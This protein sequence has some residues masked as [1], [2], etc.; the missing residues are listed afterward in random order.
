MPATATAA[1]ASP[2]HATSHDSTVASDPDVT[3]LDR[4]LAD[5]QS[6]TAV[7]RFSH[8][9][10]DVRNH[11]DV[12]SDLIPL[13]APG[14]GEQYRF[15]VDL[16]A[17]TGCKA[18]VAACHSLNGLDEGESFRTVG[19][20]HGHDDGGGADDRG[21]RPRAPALVQ[22][23][24]TACHH[25]VD[26]A[27]MH[28]CPTDA[29]EK[30]P[31]TGIVH[32]LDDQCI[33][34]SYCTLMCPYEVPRLN[35]RLGIVRKC[36]LC[37]GRLAEG[38]AP[39]C[40]QGC[41]T[42]AITVGILAVAGRSRDDLVTAGSHDAWG[43]PAVVPT[44]PPSRL[45]VPST[46]YR[47][48]EPFPTTVVAA[49]RNAAHPAHA[50][51]PLAVMLVLTQLAVGIAIGAAVLPALLTEPA[52]PGAADDPHRMLRPVLAVGSLLAGLLAIGASVL[53][54]GRPT[55]AW[56]A[57]LGLRTSWLSREIVAFGAFA[58]LAALWSVLELT[59]R[60]G[61]SM[62][63][64][65]TAT[66]GIGGVTCSALIYA[67][68][69]RRWWWA[70]RTVPTFA[71]TTAM[72]GGLAVVPLVG[73]AAIRS[74]PVMGALAPAARGAAGLAAAVGLGVLGAEARFVRHRHD[75][76]QLARTVHLLR[77][78]L[79]GPWQLRLLGTSVAT[80][81][82]LGTTLAAADPTTSPVVIVALGITALVCGTAGELTSRW[83]FFTASSPRRMPG[84]VG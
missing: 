44:A 19:T 75:S 6:L 7:E 56:K 21:G 30:D 37:R 58:V 60:A 48:R 47:R 65:A 2:T 68:T 46:L 36:D 15:E 63:G 71:A 49:D 16:D 24:T 57:V 12:W 40:V 45:T 4:W 13:T 82:A 33:G 22:T 81:L 74:G 59:G 64:L 42:S 53:H 72:L 5:Q 70:R 35:P 69:G 79:A 77:H 3:P 61:A 34:C 1:T 28:G 18:C 55:R 32:H 50:H 9:H 76:G 78:A 66:A 43:D 52:G 29:Y 25:C 20:L 83:L 39:A 31:L 26:P 73:L 11:R 27:C 38:E 84:G 14:P 51:T 67:V 62:A 23:V 10:A 17:C 54:L 41:P 8:H 80:V